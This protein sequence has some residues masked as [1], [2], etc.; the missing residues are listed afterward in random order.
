MNT[1]ST[2]K[3]LVYI[4]VMKLLGIYLIV[5]G[6]FFSF[7]SLYIYA[8]HV[9]L[10]FIISGFLSK[11]EPSAIFWKKLWQ[12][13]IVPL[14]LIFLINTLINLLNDL[15]H[16]IF[17]FKDLIYQLGKATIGMQQV[18][19]AMWFVYSLIIIKILFHFIPNRTYQVYTSIIFILLA[20]S[21]NL[22]I[23]S[24]SF[25]KEPNAIINCLLS[26]PF[27]VLGYNLRDYKER[28]DSVKPIS[29]TSLI[30]FLIS[31]VVLYFSA[32]NNAFVDMRNCGYG[33]H[34]LLFFL[35]VIAGT[36][37]I[38]LISKAIENLIPPSLSL[39][40]SIGTVLILGF[41]VHIIKMIHKF[42]P[43]FQSYDFV[44]ALVIVIAFIPI[45]YLAKRHFPYI[46]GVGRIK[47]TA[48]E[49]LTD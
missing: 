49:T 20:L 4:D 33:S 32:S 25:I 17:Q 43:P 18:L 6:H 14:I 34:I 13:L 9:P 46:I 7:G 12:N 36:I 1:V 8:F 47:K 31:G 37:L 10:F 23:P 40:I 44:I 21:F 15:R 41:H 30:T 35:G 39:I 16:G 27:F 3:R 45:I 22:Y 11:Q 42:I 24:H 29:L 28:I 26:Y 38:L 5:Y 19:G 48:N 2:K